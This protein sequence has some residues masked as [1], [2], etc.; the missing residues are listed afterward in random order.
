MSRPRS[1]KP[2]TASSAE[3]EK[4]LLKARSEYSKKKNTIDSLEAQLRQIKDAEKAVFFDV[5]LDEAKKDKDFA[6]KIISIGEGETGNRKGQ[7][8]N[9]LATI[10]EYHASKT[11]PA[12]PAEKSDD[13]LLA[14][15]EAEENR[16]ADEQS[17]AAQA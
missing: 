8:K 13:E 15:M 7:L 2:R 10:R 5:I 12:A 4:Q 3:I 14:E 16:K 11:E 1:A 9:W 17:H 6:Q